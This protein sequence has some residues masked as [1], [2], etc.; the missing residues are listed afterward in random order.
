M[1]KAL[2]RPNLPTAQTQLSFGRH[3]PRVHPG[4]C[5]RQLLRRRLSFHSGDV[6]DNYI[7]FSLFPQQKERQ[8]PGTCPTYGYSASF[9][10]CQDT[11]HDKGKRKVQQ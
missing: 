6:I 11:M 9:S 10:S 1:V 3:S 8:I 4:C 5:R 7:G 2:K